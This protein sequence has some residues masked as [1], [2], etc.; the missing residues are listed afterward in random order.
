MV[1]GPA[2]LAGNIGPLV[3]HD[4]I[5]SFVVGSMV[6]YGKPLDEVAYQIECL[7]ISM[8]LFDAEQAKILASLTL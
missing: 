4:C 5:Q 1:I 7:H 6:E 8:T 2:G 3:G